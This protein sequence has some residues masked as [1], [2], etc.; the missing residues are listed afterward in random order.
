MNPSIHP[1][2]QQTGG[3]NGG[4]SISIAPRTVWKPQ[5]IGPPTPAE[6]KVKSPDHKSFHTSTTQTYLGRKWLPPG[7]IPPRTMWKASVQRHQ[8]GIS[9]H[10][11]ITKCFNTST[12]HTKRGRQRWSSPSIPPHTVWK[13]QP[14]WLSA[15]WLGF[16]KLP[17]PGGCTITSSEQYAFFTS[18]NPIGDESG[19]SPG[20][21]SPV[22]CGNPN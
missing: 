2:T 16:V 1:Q 10:P 11:Q 8:G 20:Q 13:P 19:Y 21:Y 7:S 14:Q 22:R 12:T 4:P 18:T 17:A 5:F 6:D 3:E 15:D 9:S